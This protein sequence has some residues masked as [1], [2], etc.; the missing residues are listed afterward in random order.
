MAAV[1][2][3]SGGLVVQHLLAM[4]AVALTVYTPMQVVS[5]DIDFLSH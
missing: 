2:A 4:A 1:L 3:D 5:N